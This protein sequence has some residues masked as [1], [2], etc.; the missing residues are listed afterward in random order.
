MSLWTKYKKALEDSRN[1]TSDWN[2][3]DNSEVKV[4]TKTML[5]GIAKISLLVIAIPFYAY[6]LLLKARGQQDDSVSHPEYKLGEHGAGIYDEE[7]NCY[8]VFEDD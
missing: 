5:I 3:K 1:S 7:G 8:G 2:I 6:L 4:D